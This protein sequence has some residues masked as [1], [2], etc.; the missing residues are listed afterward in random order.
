MAQAFSQMLQ[1]N[2]TLEALSLQHTGFEQHENLLSALD[3]NKTLTE[4]HLGDS[5]LT[6]SY[7]FIVRFIKHH[8]N[9]KC[10]DLAH[11]DIPAQGIHEIAY[12]LE[13]HSQLQYLALEGNHFTPK[14]MVHLA[15]ISINH[16]SLIKIS[17]QSFC[18][19]K[20]CLIFYNHFYLLNLGWLILI[21]LRF[22]MNLIT[23][24]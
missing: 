4:L 17:V 24:L 20:K 7:S 22:L 18:L 11:S 15:Q 1:I 9:L 2:T 8:P 5:H 12:L 3:S 19:K 16:P 10:L 13:K 6:Q 21:Y 14:N 23:P